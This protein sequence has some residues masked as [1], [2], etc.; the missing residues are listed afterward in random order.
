MVRVLLT[1]YWVLAHLLMVAGT[2][3]F[4]PTVSV[5]FGFWA[6][7]S[8]LLMALALPPVLKGESFWMARHRAQGALKHNALTYAAIL[9]ALYAF[10][11]YL[12]GPRELVYA[13]DLKRWVYDAT[14]APFLPSSIEPAEGV[15]FLVGLLCALACA[16]VIRCV[17]PRRQRIWLLLGLAALSALSAVSR[18]FFDF[19]VCGQLELSV[20]WLMMFCVSCGIA[21]ESC[22]EGHPKICYTAL[23]AAAV[24]ELGIFS[25]GSPS[26]VVA[27]SLIAIVYLCFAVFAVRSSGRRPAILWQ[28]VMTLPILFAA[29]IGLALLPGGAE[30][31]ASLTNAQMTEDLDNFW[32]Q[33]GFRWDLSWQVF[34]SE[35]ILGSGPEGFQHL[36]TFFLKGRDA[37]ALW[38]E[39][40]TGVPCDFLKLMVERG[41]MGTFF[42]LLPGIILLGKCLLKWVSFQQSH[43]H[44]RYSYRYLFVLI[45]SLLGVLC[46]LLAS[47]V[48]TPLHT[49]PVLCC[50]MMVCACL[51]GWMPRRR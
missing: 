34:N 51:S 6:V 45:G 40:G 46:V 30:V 19:A 13:S 17:L 28:C 22:L 10:I 24:N 4:A 29:G 12:N 36:S 16:L 39:G 42:L 1:K 38:R 9:A 25:C 27:T 37:W 44:G 21:C 35:A 23:G 15:T 33:W 2:L 41:M 14:R 47:I 18:I 48:G 43:H 8:L 31:Q 5:G 20:L 7:C 32:R 49:P 11:G 3:C 50:F 26:V